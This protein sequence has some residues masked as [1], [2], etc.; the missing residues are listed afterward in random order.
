[1][2]TG[3]FGEV[4]VAAEAGLTNL[5]VHRRPG[6]VG[7]R[8]RGGMRGTRKLREMR[9]ILAGRAFGYHTGLSRTPVPALLDSSRA[10]IR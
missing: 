5:T 4:L 8:P 9:E 3:G 7:R 1:M 10:D 6:A 2:R